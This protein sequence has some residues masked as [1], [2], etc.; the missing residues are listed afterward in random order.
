MDFKYKLY[1][2]SIIEFRKKYV[3]RINN[4]LNK[5]LAKFNLTAD[6]AQDFFYDEREEI[7]GYALATPETADE[8][9]KLFFE[10][11]N[12]AFYYNDFIVGLFHEIGH[13][14]TIYTI[15]E[16]TREDYEEHRWSMSSIEYFTHPVEMEATLWAINYIENHI[17]EVN[18][19]WNAV[20]PLIFDFFDALNKGE[21]SWV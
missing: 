13:H 20:Q 14:H 11:L 10:S 18:E 2:I 6:L 7:I 16:F 12:P 1:N 17:T 8:E 19:L 15:D 4:E 9:F 5:Y 21:F 3:E